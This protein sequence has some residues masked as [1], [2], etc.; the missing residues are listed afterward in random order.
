[1]FDKKSDFD[2][3]WGFT[4]KK[5]K[6]LVAVFPRSDQTYTKRQLDESFDKISFRIEQVEKQ[7]W[8]NRILFDDAKIRS[9]VFFRSFGDCKYIIDCSKNCNRRKQPKIVVGMI[10]EF[11]RPF[12]QIEQLFFSISSKMVIDFIMFAP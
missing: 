4:K 12:K 1:M 2:S 10:D 7:F 3:Y 6:S 9:R 8:D 11:T 5:G